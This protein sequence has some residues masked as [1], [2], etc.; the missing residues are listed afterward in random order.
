MILRIIVLFLTSG[1]VVQMTPGQSGNKA[2]LSMFEMAWNRVNETFHDPAFGGLNWKEVHDRYLPQ[3]ASAEK[4]EVFYNL[5][6]TMLWEL[7]VSHAYIIPPG[8]LARFEPLTFADGSP[9]LDIRLLGGT[10]VITAVHPGSPAHKTGLRCGYAIQAIDDIPVEQII[11]E[12]ER[13]SPPPDNSRSRIARNTKA[14][15]SRVYGAAGTEVSIAYADESGKPG[16]RKI[17]RIKRNGVALGPGGMIFMAVEFEA[18]RLGKDIAYVRM[19]TLQ[20]ELAAR[21]S[22]AIKSMG[23]V[24]GVIIDLRGNS[25]GEIEQMPELF[26]A[27]KTL[28]YLRKDRAGE[29]KIFSSPSADAYQG[30]L[31]ILI[32]ALSGSASELFAAGMQAAKRATVMG[33]RSPGIMM[34]SDVRP[35]PNGAVFMYPVAQGKTP[36]GTVL[37]GHGVIPDIEIG[38]SRER[39]LSGVDSQLDAAV[40]CLEKATKK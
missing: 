6:N 9:G 25:G 20:P 26:L 4:D 37:E 29:K 33:E 31:V 21:T 34:E 36:D 3:I 13:I 12:A 23:G 17:T 40:K 38:L 30:P 27:E 24:S 18:R 10:A 8:T 5:L 15:L 7:K 35:F 22:A 32:D 39:L 14:L 2:Y 19:N 1:L 16:A 11:Q 28:L